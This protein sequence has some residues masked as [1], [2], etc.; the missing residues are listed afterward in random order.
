MDHNQ[1]G[2]SPGRRHFHRGRR[3]PDR[4]GPDRRGPQ[5][6]TPEQGG[7]RSD[8]DVEQIM[9]D[10]RARIAQRHGIE[11]TNQQVQEL[12]ARRLESILDPRGVKPALLDQLRRAAG[13]PP[14][15]IAASAEPPYTFEANTLYDSNRGFMRF[16]RRLLNPILKLFFNPNPLIHALNIQARLNAEALAR[17]AQRD[18]HQAEWNAL[19]YELLHRVVTEISRVTLEVQSLSMRIESLAAKVDFNERR[20]RGIEGAIHL[21]RPAARREE[22]RRDEGRRDVQEAPPP[23][24]QV[25]VQAGEGV[26]SSEP[27]SAPQGQGQSS[28]GTRRRR[29]RRRGR[30]GAGVPVETIPGAADTAALDVEESED[31]PDE[32]EVVGLMA[33][34]PA[35]PSTPLEAPDAMPTDELGSHVEQREGASVGEQEEFVRLTEQ[36]DEGRHW[37]ETESEPDVE[38][39]GAGTS[40]DHSEIGRPDTLAETQSPQVV[41]EVVVVAETQPRR[42]GPIAFETVVEELSAPSDVTAPDQPK[43]PEEEQPAPAL[44]ERRDVEP[45]DR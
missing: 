14:D 5:T 33:D 10:I 6:P 4:R 32:D 13:A 24:P 39:A 20:V 37:R 18:R 23:P 3:G 17:E 28:E 25:V 36:P 16:V 31:G 8:V 15:A 11:L 19:H 12:A 26:V 34:L 42:E 41:E 45:T 30:R 22:G 21:A 43:A 7:T 35:A 2:Q 38:Q 27:A 40:P 44:P 1:Q 9:R 29:R